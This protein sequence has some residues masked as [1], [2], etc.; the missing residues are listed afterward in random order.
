MRGFSRRKDFLVNVIDRGRLQV[1]VPVS[2]L[3]LVTVRMGKYDMDCVAGLKQT[4]EEMESK[5][6]PERIL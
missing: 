6:E 1:R 3:W 4:K 2:D 5:G